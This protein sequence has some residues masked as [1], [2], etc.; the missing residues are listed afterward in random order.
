MKPDPEEAS[1]DSSQDLSGII[2]EFLDWAEDAERLGAI[3]ELPALQDQVPM[4]PGSRVGDFMIV[5]LL[6]AG[7][8][9]RVF[10]ARQVSVDGRRVAL[11]ILRTALLDRQSITR[12]QREVAAI[13]SLD[14]EGIV[15]VL[16]ADVTG[17]LPFYAMP[18]VKGVSCSRFLRELQTE[19]DMAPRNLDVGAFVRR[20]SN[21]PEREVPLHAPNLNYFRWVAT[22]CAQLAEA[23]AHAHAADLCHRDVKPANVMITPSGRAVLLDFGLAT[24]F[25]DDSL[26]LSGAFLGT[27]A[28]S[29][30]EQARGEHT[31]ARSDVYSVGAL[32]YE[33]STLRKAF[34]SEHRAE[35]LRRIEFD[36]PPAMGQNVP[37]DLRA[38]CRAAMSKSPKER[39]ATANDLAQDLRSHLAGRPLKARRRAYWRLA[40]LRARQHPFMTALAVFL[41]IIA[42]AK[43]QDKRSAASVVQR[44]EELASEYYENIDSTLGLLAEHSS[45]PA[46]DAEHISEVD[47]TPHGLL[48]RVRDL[49]RGF[50]PAERELQGAFEHVAGHAGARE[51]LAELHAARLVFALEQAWDILRPAALR[52]IETEVLAY[53]D[54]GTHADLLQPMGS[55]RLDCEAAGA[56]IEVWR[57]DAP[58]LRFQGSAPLDLPALREGSYLAKATAP[59]MAACVL[60]FLVRRDAIYKREHA[61][62]SR[63]RTI[64]LFPHSEIG[65]SWVVIP[66]GW[67]LMVD[68]P[69]RWSFVETFMIQRLEVTLGEWVEWMNSI[70][71]NPVLQGL[72]NTPLLV[73]DGSNFNLIP[74]SNGGHLLMVNYDQEHELWSLPPGASPREPVR[75]LSRHDMNIFCGSL[76]A[77]GAPLPKD[78]MTALPSIPQWRRAARGADGRLYP[79]GSTRPA[80]AGIWDSAGRF[81]DAELSPSEVGSVPGDRSPF[82][83]RDMAGSVQEATSSLAGRIRL[84]WGSCGGSYRS[85]QEEQMQVTA[86]DSKL[87]EPRWE[88]GFRAIKQPI[89]TFFLPRDEPPASFEDDFERPDSSEVG[90]AWHELTTLPGGLTTDPNAPEEVS[91][92]AGSLVCRGGMGNGSRS[93]TAAHR[94]SPGP[95]GILVEAQLSCS[96]RGD[97]KLRAHGLTLWS[98][99]GINQLSPIQLFVQ[100]DGRVSI[101]TG[102]L[103]SQATS[104]NSVPDPLG[105]KRFVIEVRR[106]QVLGRVLALDGTLLAELVLPQPVPRPF[107]RYLLFTGNNLNGSRLQVDEVKVQPLE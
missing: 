102:G 13:A 37:A 31:D 57:E 8:M 61:R 51:A 103:P 82:D 100:H 65:E 42:G 85:D 64:S 28:Y 41:A 35:L 15:P 74:R 72:A 55:A 2:D 23:L 80:A 76:T 75:G 79:W 70:P 78:W 95:E 56:T 1:K 59:G 10:E 33:L 107:P 40:W 81:Q 16:A 63:E 94:I 67:T 69:A 92:E 50:A 21:L 43:L 98:R 77:T 12:F 53:D 73:P 105:P 32:L 20:I 88:V 84:S 4:G 97:P 86:T 24:R 60:H 18:Y 106:D 7:G 54:Y 93:S 99:L 25:G 68:V 9:G 11:K 22:L 90:N 30:P 52:E 96:H 6:G 58:E 3:R 83:V 47:R 29:A 5:R 45:G 36:E 101:S 27:L 62:P 19:N 89:D 46:G 44:G 87:A 71:T 66:G 34:D 39:Y 14:H 17:D 26:T 48:D 38:I 104:R 49:E 91:I